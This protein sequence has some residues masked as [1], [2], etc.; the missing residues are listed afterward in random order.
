MAASMHVLITG[1]TGVIGRRLV[2]D[3]L[4]RGDVVTVVSRDGDRAS[5]IFAAQSNP[6][7]RVVEGD[8]G[9]PGTWQRAVDGVDAVVHLAAAGI[10]DRRWSA[11]Y[12]RTIVESRLDSTHQVIVAIEEASRRP[13]VLVS[14]SATGYYGN[15]GDAELTESSEAGRDFLADLCVRWEQQAIAAE[16]AG[17]RTALLRIGVVL[18]E[19]GGALPRMLG[20]FRRG[21]GGTMGSGR[22]W[23]PWVHWR[24]VVGTIDLAINR[25]QLRGPMN[26]V[27]PGAVTNLDFTRALARAVHRPALIPMPYLG[28]RLLVGELA[29]FLVSSQRAVPTRALEHG[30]RFLAP[31]LA[32]ALEDLVGRAI[33]GDRAPQR[34][35]SAGGVQPA[36]SSARRA[37]EAVAAPRGARAVPLVPSVGATGVP[38]AGRV[39]DAAEVLAAGGAALRSGAADGPSRSAPQSRA[40]DVDERRPRMPSP[41]RPIRLVAIDVDGT[42]LATDGTLAPPVRLAVQRAM[43][44]GV[45]VVL[46]T[47]RSPRLMNQVVEMLGLPGPTINFNGAVIWNP[48]D[49]RAQ[50][51][52]SLAPELAQSIIAALRAVDR[53]VVIEIDVLDRCHTDRVDRSLQAAV[54]RLVD[55]T[56]IGPLEAVL[57]A[58]VTRINVLAPPERLARVLEPIRLGLWRERKVAMFISHPHM[59]QITAPL[60]DKGIALQRVARRLGAAREEVMAIGDAAN[61]M[62]MLEWAGFGVALANATATVRSVANAVAPTNDENGVAWAIERWVIPS[63]AAIA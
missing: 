13:R 31:D 61:D 36:V 7:V 14:A 45:V 25:E 52:E 12:R 59:G 17:V 33:A 40:H 6:N 63:R 49:H 42:L 28:L 29:R 3:R 57:A 58:P 18:D 19:R 26:A 5:R 21:L 53:D 4:G 23:L 47:A 44:N 54:S 9:V 30:Y 16:D 35:A 56:T 8:C 41:T 50:H 1:A 15:A 48:L 22:Q 10:A 39:E 32:A 51:H 27:A 34:P 37:P 55:P 60:V 20:F 43:R 62:G 38:H 46:S 24:D 2:L 11:D